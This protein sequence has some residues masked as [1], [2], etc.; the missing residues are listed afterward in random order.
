MKV[1]KVRRAVDDA[2]SYKKLGIKKKNVSFKEDGMR[3]N[4]CSGT[5]EWWYVDAEF[6]DGTTMVNVF[7]TKNGFDV[8][9]KAHPRSD[10]DITLPDGTE[11]SRKI[12]GEKGK[13]I[14][15]KKDICDVKIGTSSLKYV[16]GVYYIH[17][18]SEGI[19]YDAKMEN[20][21]PMWR[22]N[23]GFTFYGENDANYGAWLV[24]QPASKITGT[25]EINGEVKK[26]KGTGYHDHNWGNISTNKALD[27]WY[28]G[29][30]KVGDYT[31]IACD[32]I[33][34]KRYGSLRMPR[35]MIARDGKIIEDNAAATIIE[36][37]KT[38]YNPETKKFMDDVLVYTQPVSHREKY[39]I[40]FERQKDIMVQNLLDQFSK[41]LRFFGKLAGANPT[42]VRVLGKVT[43]E[44][45]V[46]GKSTIVESTGLWEQMALGKDKEATINEG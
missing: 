33:L 20:L 2:A 22:Q 26:I 23:S 46:D 42:Y 21:L 13:V 10:F 31:I 41:G 1:Q 28:W 34:S 12:Y 38:H 7:F 5:Y 15:A 16:D 32:M 39:I 25:L 8:P 17:Y 37:K 24:A 9:G 45:I 29:R 40:T 19:K 3:T 6:E 44:H 30:A 4:G 18:E 36:R 14:D 27:H 35:M 11:I 43:L